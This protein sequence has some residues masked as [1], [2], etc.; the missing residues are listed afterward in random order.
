M[1]VFLLI[2]LAIAVIGVLASL[3][4]RLNELRT[5]V[6]RLDGQAS[7]RM[8]A[9]E[10][11]LGAQERLTAELRLEI[12]ETAPARKGASVESSVAPTAAASV[13][14]HEPGIQHS[15]Q[16]EARPSPVAPFIAPQS[17]PAPAPEPIPQATEA[18]LKSPPP[19]PQPAPHTSERHSPAA[20]PSTALPAARALSLEERLGA[21]WLNKLG[22]AILVIGLA[23]FLA[24]RLTTMSPGG[25]VLTGLAIS[26]ALL[27]GGIW[28]ERRPTYRVFA[29]AGIGG[30]WAL[31]FFTTYAMHHLEATR[32][33]SSLI[34]DLLLMLAVAAG[35][36]LHSLRYRSQ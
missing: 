33:I 7:D 2:I 32:I 15:P 23:F 13:L 24:V 11:R 21:N 19:L 5:T 34:A 27:G 18:V 6:E 8:R 36:V 31:L 29:R 22:I 16:A 1:G 17:T 3:F 20:P 4:S 10:A 12:A 14:W 28:L 30:G 26:L 35:M 25:K 9:L